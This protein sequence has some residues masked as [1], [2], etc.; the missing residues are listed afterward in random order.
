MTFNLIF[1]Q[2]LLL[3]N[4]LLFFIVYNNIMLIFRFAKE[5]VTEM[6]WHT[7]AITSI[8]FQP[9]DESVVTVASADNRISTWD[10][11]VEPDEGQKQEKNEN[12]E[13]IPDQLIF[14]H[15]GQEDVKEIM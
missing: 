6:Q 12:E 13:E 10:F 9:D 1:I 3:F 14:L 7:E 8:Y 11:A 4:I 15:Q 5:P 2:V